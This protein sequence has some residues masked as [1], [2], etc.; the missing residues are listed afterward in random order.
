GALTVS[1]NIATGGGDVTLFADTMTFTGTVS[2]GTGTAYLDT[3]LLNRPITLGTTDATKLSFT[4]SALGQLTARVLRVGDENTDTGGLVI[5]GT[6]TRHAGWSTL[7]LRQ[8]SPISQTA[9][10]SVANLVARTNGSNA[11]TL[12]NAGNDVDVIAGFTIAGNF[13][14]ADSNALTIG[15]VVDRTSITTSTGTITVTAAGALTST[16]AGSATGHTYVVDGSKIVRDSAAAIN[17]STPASVTVT[18]GNAADTFTVTPSS[19]IA[20]T[21]NGNPPTTSPGDTLTVDLT[22]TTSPTLSDSGGSGNYTFGNRQAVNFTSIESVNGPDLAITKTDGKTS[23]APG[24]QDTYT[25]VATNNGPAAASGV[26]ITDTFPATFTSVSYTAVATGTATGFTASGTGNIADTASMPA[27]STITY[28]VTGT[29]TSSATGSI[30]N[31]ATIGIPGITES[32]TTNNSQTDTDTLT[33]QAD[34]RITKTDGKTSAIPGTQDTYTIVVSNNGPSNVTGASVTDTFPATFTGVTFTA[35]QLGGATGFTAN[36]SGNI[37]DIVNMPSGASITY[38]A[39]GTISPSATGSLA[40][41]ASVSAPS[42]T[43]ELDGTNNQQTDTDT[44]TP[45]TDLVVTK[46]GPSPV[47]ARTNFNYTIKVGNLGPSTATGVTMTDTL[48]PD[49]HIVSVSAPGY[50]CPL[51]TSFKGGTLTCSRTSAM[52]PSATAQDTITVTGNFQ[53][54]TT[55]TQ[56]ERNTARVSSTTTDLATTNNTSFVD[57]TI[58]CQPGGQS[59][60]GLSGG[61]GGSA[62]GGSGSGGGVAGT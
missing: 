62:C 46:T 4:D 23:A 43:T 59:G 48:P 16:D 11:M 61:S 19:D 44:L 13:T 39:T 5:A 17:Y 24:A 1:N 41:T 3:E 21:V 2:A 9:S 49:F 18:G 31:T 52:S 56:T 33:P 54:T 34:L 6:V 37:S 47:T 51:P 40:N 10:L 45:R 55:A 38:T 25:I 29:I 42:G 36:G 22:G 60:S 35:T 12:T 27:G 58:A 20:F 14:Y 57:T 53:P 26:K 50:N 32:N 8:N 30:A 15:T 7:D 28:T